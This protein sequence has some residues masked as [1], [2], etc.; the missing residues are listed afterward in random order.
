V[1][2]RPV[3]DLLDPEA[4]QRARPHIR[5]VL[6]GDVVSFENRLHLP[7]VG[8]KDVLVS[9]APRRTTDGRIDGFYSAAV[10]ISDQ[11]RRQREILERTQQYRAIADSIPYGIWTCDASGRLTYVS[12]SFLDLVGMSFARAANFGWISKLIPESAKE[13]RAA[14]NACVARN[15]NWER[16]HRFV[17]SDGRHYDILAIARP[18]FDESGRLLSYVGLNLDITERKH[19]EETLALLSAELDHRVKNVFSLVTT[20]AR[21]SSRT[22]LTVEAFCRD[23]EGRMRALSVAHEMI[24]E[25]GWKGMSLRTLLET[26]LA[27][28]RGGA[29][30]AFRLDGPDVILPIR[31]VQPLVLAFHELATNAAKYGALS[32]T[33]GRLAVTWT[34]DPSARLAVTWDESGLSGITAPDGSGFGSRVLRQ[35]LEMQ[36]GA[37]VVVDYRDT[38]LLVSI[39]LPAGGLLPEGSDGD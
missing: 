19:R 27:P 4:D 22:A 8:E 37:E 31:S 20:I 28:Y 33:R 23:F 6:E 18:V 15:H 3:S 25:N 17:G 9:L 12:E 24:A 5:R 34:S 11:K 39:C 1:V 10:D 36:L 14:W 35:V 2:G 21:Q 13:T 7:G 32:E 26:E 29:H 30:E 38:G 16:E